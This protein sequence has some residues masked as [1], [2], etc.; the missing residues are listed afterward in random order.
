MFTPYITI[1]VVTTTGQV[2]RISGDIFAAV[3]R[4]TTTIPHLKMAV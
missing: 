1:N 3:V 4:T 2:D